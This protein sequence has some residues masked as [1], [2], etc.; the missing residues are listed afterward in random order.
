M[1]KVRWILLPLLLFCIMA[2]S[3]SAQYVIDNGEILTAEE[4][5]YLES[6]ATTQSTA[7]GISFVILTEQGIDGADPYIHAAD[8]YDYGGY[9]DDGV[10]LL[11]D[12][13]ERGWYFVTSG[14]MNQALGND[15]T[16][17]LIETYAVP[18]F[19][20]GAYETG[21]AEYI[22]VVS[23]LLDGT[24]GNAP[25]DDGYYN[26]DYYDDGYYDNG[27][28][29]ERP[30]ESNGVDGAYYVIAFGVALL[31]AFLVC[32]GFKA[33]LNTA[34]KKSGATD[35]F[36][37]NNINMTAS[38]D[39]FLYSRT[40]KVRKAENNNSGS[41]GKSGRSSGGSMRSFSGSSGR[42]HRGGG[43]RF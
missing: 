3:V 23:G 8:V 35:Y 27:Y 34:V 25:H 41:G 15:E 32:N 21:F 26:N 4:E 39:R 10:I 20:Q 42:S 36:D 17:D 43:G 19:S 18:W 5:A 31:V 37:T 9:L 24:L 6:V 29:Y 40:T 22:A 11:L 13:G 30:V 7:H 28:Y 1:K 33:Q 2:V 12:M 16:L 38:A 14:T